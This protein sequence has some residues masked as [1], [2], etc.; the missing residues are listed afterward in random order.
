M[1]INLLFTF[2]TL[3]SFTISAKYE[4]IKSYED[5]VSHMKYFKFKKK[6][7]SYLDEGQGEPLFFLHGI[8]TNSWMFR[9]IIPELV[10]SGYRVI[11]PDLFNA[12]ASGRSENE[13]A[14]SLKAQASIMIKFLTKHLKLEKWSH[15]VHDM[16]GPIT[17]EMMKNKRFKVNKFIF[18]N[19]VLFKKGFHPKLNF[20]T[21]SAISLLT[22]PHLRR[23]FYYTAINKMVTQQESLSEDSCAGYLDPI[24]SG[25]WYLHKSLYFK[26]NKLKKKLKSY[27]KLVKAKLDPKKVLI[28][29]GED[30]E[31]LD[32]HNQST[33]IKE[34]LGLQDSQ[35]HILKK[36][37]H[38]LTEERPKEIIRL[39]K[40][41]KPIL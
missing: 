7:I 13:K 31:F 25:S 40:T 38:L 26:A 22:L 15:V 14:I 12:G 33:Q 41:F 19:T 32:A 23:K 35:I 3:C 27:Q 16:G 24:M 5:H 21:K 39:I 29:W 17:W 9:K 10:E 20:F 28:I 18:F 11:I 8:P 37:K 2:L 30:D 4:N 6:T 1:N 36:T 34:L